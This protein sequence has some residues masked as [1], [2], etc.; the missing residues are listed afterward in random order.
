MSNINTMT[1]EEMAALIAK[2]TAENAAL[3]KGK[4]E[5]KTSL[6]V[7]QKGAVS[8][9]GLGRWPVTLYASQ[10]EK[11]LAKADQIRQFIADNK[12]KLSVKEEAVAAEPT[13]IQNA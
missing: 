13:T 10:W 7:S 6:K 3:A 4:G 12:D 2:L 9:Y 11:L 1:Q 8:L 5:P